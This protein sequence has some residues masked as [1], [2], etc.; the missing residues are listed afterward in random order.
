MSYFPTVTRASRPRFLPLF[1]AISFAVAGCTTS[2]PSQWAIHPTAQPLTN[3]HAHNDYEHTHP[4]FD[5][6]DCGICSVEADVHLIAGELYVA[7]NTLGIRPGRTLE[8]LYLDP[9]A[10]RVKQNGG[11]VFP[12]GPTV[13]LLI[14][15]KTE[16]EATYAQVVQTLIKYSDILTSFEDDKRTERAITVIMTGARARATMEAEKVH[17]TAYD[18]LL[19]DDLNSNASS[20][21]IPWISSKWGDTFKWTGAGPF[22]DAE[23]RKLK[24]I[25]AKAHAKNRKLRFWGAPD[26]PMMWKILLDENV[27]LIN[28]DHLKECSDFVRAYGQS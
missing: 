1:I 9:L 21:F 6:L 22:P 5:A 24:E 3:I 10:K 16:P 14:D 23:R 27:D 17:L 4:L 18:G 15:I 13:V 19:P 28:T 7:H 20:D 11:R 8:K 12:N 26:N 2:S 25:V